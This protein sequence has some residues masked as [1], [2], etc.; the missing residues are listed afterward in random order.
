MSSGPLEPLAS[1][2]LE[3][4]AGKVVVDQ[5]IFG[6]GHGHQLLESTTAFDDES[7]L[8]LD[9]LT[10]GTGA[11][12]LAGFD[13]YLSGFPLPDSRYVFTRTWRAT[14]AK[15]PGSVW[16]HAVIIGRN[17]LAKISDPRPIIGILKTRPKVNA[18]AGPLKTLRVSAGTTSPIRASDLADWSALI[19]ALTASDS[20]T[21]G[22]TLR[23]AADGEAGV[24]ALWSW[25]WPAVRNG[26]AFSFGATSRPSL[27]K[28]R[29]FDLVGVPQSV[30]FGGEGIT[31]DPRVTSPA[32]TAIWSEI[33]A[34]RRG[35]LT[36]Y[37]RFCGAETSRRTAAA[38]LTN[39]WAVATN[40][41][42]DRN[43]RQL[44]LAE[45]VVEAFPDPTAMRRLKR[46]VFTENG[47]L[48]VDWDPATTLEILASP[49]VAE[50]VLADDV[51]LD[52]LV[53]RAVNN[54]NL[55]LHAYETLDRAEAQL[56]ADPMAIRAATVLT[57]LPVAAETAI[58]RFAA[59]TWMEELVAASPSLT[60][61]VLRN[62]HAD[63]RQAWAGRFWALPMEDQDLVSSAYVSSVRAIRTKPEVA[64]SEVPAPTRTA[65]WLAAYA[66]TTTGG[67]NW[68]ATC[69]PNE[70]TRQS[71]MLDLALALT[72][73]EPVARLWIRA[74]HDR[75]LVRSGVKAARSDRA[76]PTV[77]AALLLLIEPEVGT[78]NEGRLKSWA[79]VMRSD[80]GGVGGAHLLRYAQRSEAPSELEI[81][82]LAF[83]FA[84]AW[85]ALARRDSATWDGLGDFP[86]DA[87]PGREWDRAYR[88]TA[89]LASLVRSWRVADAQFQV[90]HLLGHTYGID[91]SAAQQLDEILS[92]RTPAPK[93]S[94][95]KIAQQSRRSRL[96]PWRQLADE[97]R[98]MLGF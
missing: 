31:F 2:S 86:A 84:E 3:S 18:D 90:D 57:E 71:A 48:P 9:R 63:D 65:G 45:A 73:Y 54:P 27:E 23:K 96:D 70:K 1:P 89:A 28:G 69:H 97:V 74:V 87:E 30:K 92:N 61:S 64:T 20:T 34:L 25:L 55:L 14:E 52:G 81:E 60:A 94:P 76:S 78:A 16:T 22:V 8:R 39:V 85:T 44:A 19:T 53:E 33:A 42:I 98:S 91:P 38:V 13:G 47:R 56:Q 17:A 49:R 24:S 79:K 40:E 62:A 41:N 43:A 10:D 72:E 15:R 67:V 66:P 26:F 77:A 75:A 93:A 29:Y 88:L 80:I 36:Q 58:S 51:E 5:A 11:E 59:P 83:G 12:A 35:E 37:V 50:C 95:A 21:V 82:L 32:G 46:S 4:V 6:Y 68:L 7:R